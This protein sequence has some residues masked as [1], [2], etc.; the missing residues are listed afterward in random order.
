MIKL[1]NF[2]FGKCYFVCAAH[3]GA[4]SLGAS[5]AAGGEM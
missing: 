1:Y 2:R 5:E 4:A 3:R